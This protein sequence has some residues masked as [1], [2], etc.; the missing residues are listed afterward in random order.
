[1]GPA[2]VG[3]LVPAQAQPSKAAQNGGF[4]L[5][6]TASSVCIFNAQD[7]FAAMLLCEAVVKQRNI[8]GADMGVASRRRSH[9][10]SNLREWHRPLL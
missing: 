3:T 4:G 7:E 6:I 1:M 5:G 9:A 10:G 2:D 8:S